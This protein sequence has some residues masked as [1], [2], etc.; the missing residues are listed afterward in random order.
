MRNVMNSLNV[1]W[2]I[3]STSP[4]AEPPVE[5]TKETSIATSEIE[6]TH[7]CI[8][9]KQEDA[10]RLDEKSSPM[11]TSE[12]TPLLDEWKPEEFNNTKPNSSWRSLPSRASSAVVGAVKVVFTYV[13]A[14]FKYVI[15]CFIDEQ[16]RI[17]PLL[18][19]F[20]IARAINPR[21]RRRSVQPMAHS[22]TE[23]PIT[24]PAHAADIHSSKSQSQ[25]KPKRSPSVASSSTAVT[26]DSE[27]DDKVRKDDDDA[28]ARNT[29]SKST[30]APEGEEIAPQRRSIRIKLHNEE[31]LRRIRKQEKEETAKDEPNKEEAKELVAASLKSPSGSN[32]AVKLTKFPRAP[33]PPRPLVPRRQP[34]YTN[35]TTETPKHMT[36]LILDLDETLIHSHSKGGRF[37]SGHMVEVKMSHAVGV[38]GVTIGPQV[39]I[40]YYVH[41]RPHCDEFLRKVRQLSQFQIEPD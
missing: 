30:P 8:D 33:L 21:K 13:A 34:S 10:V 40:L 1:L 4:P 24:A 5:G 14:P 9:G 6:Q 39:P 18:P 11:E 32:S 28:P 26:T 23:K 31:A 15:T 19:V 7:M 25:K 2:A 41:K 38:G 3:S 27:W 17:S 35:A 16:G 29:R 12:H 36:T 37:A 22:S 20:T